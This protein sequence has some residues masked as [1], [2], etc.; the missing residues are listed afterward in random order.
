MTACILCDPRRFYERALEKAP[1]NTAVMD[2]LG[3]LLVG[4]GQP[5]KAKEVSGKH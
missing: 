4:L 3:E 1:E 5:E 2:S